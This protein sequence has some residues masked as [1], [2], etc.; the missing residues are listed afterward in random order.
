MGVLHLT[1]ADVEKLLDMPAAID[2]VGE[3]F[4]QLA[5][6]NAENIPRARV[7]TDGAVLHTMSAGAS[8]LGM[9][10]WKAYLTTRK[11]AQFHVGLYDQ[12]SGR[13]IALI[14][15]DRLGQIRTGATTA[16]A[17]KLLTR[18]DVHELGLIGVG[19]QAEAQLVGVANVRTI[20]RAFVY[21]RDAQRREN[22]AERMQKLLGQEVVP[23]DRPQRAVEN[24]PLVITATTAAQPVFDGRWLSPGTVVCA[25]GSNWLHKAELDSEVIRRADRIVCDSIEACRGEAGDFVDALERG[26]FDWSMATELADVAAGRVPSVRNPDAIVL[27]KSVGLA[28]EDLAVA[29]LVARRARGSGGKLLNI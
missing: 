18:H 22:F 2:A 12:Q 10:A 23:V 25:M 20:R 14:Q 6:G 8:Y 19:W 4:R 24:L 1:E 15:A 29:A 7:R 27:F 16:V 13:M 17:V 26:I 21:S 5:A 11:G 3:A 28:L 9:A